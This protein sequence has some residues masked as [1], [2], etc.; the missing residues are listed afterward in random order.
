MNPT[1]PMRSASGRSDHTSKR[2]TV[3]KRQGGRRDRDGLL[4]F[5]S[6]RMHVL[7]TTV[8]QL[9]VQLHEERVQAVLDLHIA[10]GLAMQKER[11]EVYDDL[12]QL[13]NEALSILRRDLVKVLARISNSVTQVETSAARGGVSYIA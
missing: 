11:S 2:Q 12:A 4:H 3:T 9:T 5:I 1:R 13:P 10:S 7:E 8:H 6:E